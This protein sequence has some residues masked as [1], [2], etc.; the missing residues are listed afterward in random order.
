MIR[1]VI[2]VVLALTILA[3]F[4]FGIFAQEE[5]FQYVGMKNCKMCHTSKKSGESYKIW[6]ESA[7]ATAYQTLANEQSQKIAAEMGIEDPQKDEKCLKCHVTG[8]GEPAS[9]YGKDYSMEEGV[10]CEACHGPGSEYKSM[11]IM[12]QIY[13]GE[14]EGSKYG[15]VEP[16]AALCKT[17]HNEESPTFK[18]FDYEKFVAQIAHPVPSGK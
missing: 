18:G 9:K 10:T 2:S 16:D 11:K 13:A 17:C 7:H 5:E 6:Q 4:S 14:V 3:F 1:F 12:K 8:Y 15:L